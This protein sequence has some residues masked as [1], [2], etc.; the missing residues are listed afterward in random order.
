MYISENNTQYFNDSLLFLSINTDREAIASTTSCSIIAAVIHFIGKILHIDVIPDVL[1]I[2][3]SPD[4][5]I[6]PMNN[7]ADFTKRDEAKPEN[8]FDTLAMMPK[9]CNETL[10]NKQMVLLADDPGMERGP[11]Q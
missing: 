2:N 11:D 4:V 1:S 10:I 8:M 6:T 9:A 3:S 7:V 5:V